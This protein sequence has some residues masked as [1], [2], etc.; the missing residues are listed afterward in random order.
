M[1]EEVN[2]IYLQRLRHGP[3]L[4]PILAP[5]AGFD[6]EPRLLNACSHEAGASQ[7][8]GLWVN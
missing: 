2:R 4:D 7:S 6:P 3:E 8:D 5:L 1:R